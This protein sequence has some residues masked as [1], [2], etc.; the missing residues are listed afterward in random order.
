MGQMIT[1]QNLKKSL[2]RSWFRWEDYIKINW[3][4][5]GQDPVAYSAE[6]SNE[7]YREFLH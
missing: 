1:S 3:T 7:L 4:E 2:K 5:S 6:Y